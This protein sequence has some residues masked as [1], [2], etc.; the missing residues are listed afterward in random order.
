MLGLGSV[1]RARGGG[2]G[3]DWV[4]PKLKPMWCGG[5]VGQASGLRVGKMMRAK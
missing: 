3:C 2:L 4:E 1:F 5:A